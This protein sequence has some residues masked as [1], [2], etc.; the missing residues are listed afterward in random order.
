MT[1]VTHCGCEVEI[2]PDDSHGR[3]YL[4]RGEW[5][6][7]VREW[8]QEWTQPGDTAVDIG[9]KFGVHT[10]AFR[11]AVGAEGEVHAFEPNPD[12]FDYL[13]ATV[14]RNGFEN[15]LTWQKGISD[16]RRMIEYAVEDSRS[17]STEYL[18]VADETFGVAEARLEDFVSEYDIV[19][20]DVE[21]AEARILP[22]LDLEM[23]RAIIVEIHPDVLSTD[24][25][26]RIIDRLAEDGSV[27]RRGN[28]LLWVE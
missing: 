6:P 24:R 28:R 19:K 17:G 4:E 23:A 26:D 27:E 5:E 18:G 10:V 1:T 14:D 7:D 25:V 21:G 9:A 3:S 15:V 16:R 13:E 11:G 2:D 8:I 22:T 20:M 12:F